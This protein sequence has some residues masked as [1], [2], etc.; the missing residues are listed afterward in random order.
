MTRRQRKLL[1]AAGAAGLAV[2]AWKLAPPRTPHGPAGCDAALWNHVYHPARLEV[3]E[4]CKTVEGEI[5]LVRHE[6]DGDLHILLDVADKSLL[7]EANFS[8][9]HG[10]LVLEPICQKEPTQEDA[11]EPCRNYA[12]PMFAVHKGMRVRVTGSYVRDGK[13]GGWMEIHPVTSMVAIP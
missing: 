11:I 6:D 2:A 7:S 10:A 8:K 12:G 3:I 4:P 9:Q 5:V 1:L 13:H